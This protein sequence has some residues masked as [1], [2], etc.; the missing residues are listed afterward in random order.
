LAG[1]VQTE[2]V[3]CRGQGGI[4]VFTQSSRCLPHQPGDAFCCVSPAR[5]ADSSLTFYKGF[6]TFVKQNSIVVNRVAID[7]ET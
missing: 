1:A 3:N 5:C 2:W 6:P 7:H 4:T